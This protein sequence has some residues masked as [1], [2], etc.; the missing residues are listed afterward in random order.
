MYIYIVQVHVHVYVGAIYTCTHVQYFQ[1]N[2]HHI[3]YNYNSK[4]QAEE[5]HLK[6][7][8]RKIKNKLSAADSRRR[9][10]NYVEGL[11][12]RVEKCTSLNRKLQ[13][14]VDSLEN[15]NRYLYMQHCSIAVDQLCF[16]NE[17]LYALCVVHGFGCCFCLLGVYF[18]IMCMCM[19][20]YS[21]MCVCSNFSS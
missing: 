16:I 12:H 1:C 18:C 11:E 8:R 6:R 7:I 19:Y 3:Q 4:L 15:E 14:R 2:T 20:M 17:A 21:T 13:H 10:K 5:K 9:K